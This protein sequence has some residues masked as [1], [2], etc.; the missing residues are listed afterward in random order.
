[1]ELRKRHNC[2]NDV[3]E[4]LAISFA[5]TFSAKLFLFCD[6]YQDRNKQNV[7]S[8][9]LVKCAFCKYKGSGFLVFFIFSGVQNIPPL[10]CL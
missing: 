8:A 10:K 7:L 5:M 6:N 1:M 3:Q 2:S 9:D 4:S